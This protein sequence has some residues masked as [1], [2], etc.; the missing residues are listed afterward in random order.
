MVINSSHCYSQITMVKA[1]K[2]KA[3][4]KDEPRKVA[5]RRILG[6]V[7]KKLTV[8]SSSCCCE[9]GDVIGRTPKHYSVSGVLWRPGSV[10]RVWT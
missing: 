2:S 10:P 3:K 1:K 4:A 6:C 8:L 5:A 9:C 7:G